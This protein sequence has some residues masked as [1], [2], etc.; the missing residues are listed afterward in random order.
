MELIPLDDAGRL[1]LSADPDEWTAIAAAD[2]R[3]VIDLDGCPDTCVPTT[4][5]GILF[6]Y[7]PFSDAELPNLDRLHAVARLGATLIAR[8]QKVL[9]HC[10]L[11][12]NRS[13]LVAGLILRYLGASGPEAV[14]RLRERR[15]GALYNRK[16]AEYVAGCELRPA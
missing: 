1:F 10:G 3:V 9:S 6:V 15:P 2:I 8:G 11:G 4:P 13:A 14:A 12:Y 7:F 16:Y 5:D